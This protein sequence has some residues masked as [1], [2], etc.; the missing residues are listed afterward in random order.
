MFCDLCK[1]FMEITKNVSHIEQ[2]GGNDDS[3]SSNFDVSISSNKKYL[4][5]IIL[6]LNLF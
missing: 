2:H 3:E 5:L 4:K 1:N 6:L